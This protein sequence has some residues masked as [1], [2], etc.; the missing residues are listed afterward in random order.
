MNED[1][2][3][4]KL[5]CPECSIPDEQVDHA[6]KRVQ[7]VTDELK[8]W[9]P[10]MRLAMVGCLI[11]DYRMPPIDVITAVNIASE[12]NERV[13]REKALQEMVKVFLEERRK[14]L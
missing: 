4:G 8:D 14:G 10:G 6:A 11:A 1:T 2:K 9:T 5:D 7:E 3:C 12:S 13:A